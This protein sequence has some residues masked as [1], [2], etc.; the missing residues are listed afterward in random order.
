MTDKEFDIQI[1]SMLQDAEEP[2]P[3]GVWEGVSAALDKAP[4]KRVIP[5]WWWRSAGIAAAAAAVA[6]GVF[7]WQPKQGSFKAVEN[8]KNAVAVVAVPEVSVPEVPGPAA[9]ETAAAAGQFRPSAVTARPAETAPA[10]TVAAPVIPDEVSTVPD[11][12]L[13]VPDEAPVISSDPSVISSEAEKSPVSS[14]TKTPTSDEAPAISDEAPVISG[15]PFAVI[16]SEAEK[17]PFHR[18]VA[19]SAGGSALTN[20][21]PFAPKTGMRKAASM[22][23]VPRET[24]ITSIGKSTYGLP[25]TVG[26]GVRFYVADRFSIGT[27]V[28]YSMLTRS[29]TG[30]Y[31][32]VNDG[33]VVRSVTTDIHNDQ[34]YIG[35]PLQV[36][37]DFLRS[38]RFRAYVHAGGEV[39]RS[40]GN[41]YRIPHEGE[42]IRYSEKVKGVQWSVGGGVGVELRL[43]E[44][45][46]IYLDP[47]LRYYFDC[48]QPV[49]IRTTQP[50]RMDFNLGLRFDV[51]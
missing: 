18:R 17:S 7:L 13:T 29:F 50:L 51:L 49:S 23:P 45:V 3:E 47:G 8:D 37:Y 31:N 43:G 33:A 25:F 40:V 44:H 20:G 39:E 5:I 48:R 6:L 14:D 41:R 2:V 26:L 28:D 30:T 21:N 4:R 34:H 46:G 15:D 27:G 10:L 12:I 42:T 35:I 24:G 19:F 38:G 36:Y 9:S 16:S 32:E 1:R 22:I 11:E